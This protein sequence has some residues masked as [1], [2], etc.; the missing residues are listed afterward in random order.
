MELRPYQKQILHELEHLPAIGLFMGTGTGKTI[1]S[2]YRHI[3]NK[4][5]YLLILCPAKVVPQWKAVIPTVIKDIS[6]VNFKPS[7]TASKI[8]EE[9]SKINLA[10][11]SAIVLSLESISRI[12]ILEKIVDEQ[13]TLI[14]DES[15][16]IKEF[17]TK[18][19]PV[20]VTRSALAIG[21]KTPFKLILT[22]TP[23]QKEKGGYIDYYTQLSFLGYMD[24]SLKEFKDRY[25]I[26]T[27][28][29]PLGMP[30]PID[31]IKNYK[32]THEIDNL[33]MQCCRRYT[34]KFG[35]FEPQHTK[36]LLPLA[37]SYTKLSR[38]KAYKDLDLM[39]LSSRRIAKKTLTGGVVI[40]HDLYGEHLRYEDNT[41]K[42][43]WVSEFLSDTDERVVI[44]Y[45]YNV[46]L[47]TLKK[48]CETNNKRYIVINGDNKHKYQ[49]IMRD[50]YDVVLGQFAAAGESLDGLQYKAHI[51]VYYAMPESSLAHRQALGRIDRDGQTS[52]PMYYYLVMDKTIDDDIYKMTEKKIEFSEETLNKVALAEDE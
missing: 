20:K 24:M 28:F 17:G 1:T 46:E 8:N 41:I 49:D 7:Y 9:L 11:P 51:C 18:R 36:I 43:D 10:K 21:L 15:H 39:N 50:D 23:T 26:M 16:K 12:P 38:E 52:V 6:I 27:R 44:F 22:A 2:L 34:A 5:K 31:I 35:D 25:C 4:T 14:V 45:Q 29:Q 33:L 37:K 30:F 42:S 3:E 19:N 32:N 40:G 13:W 48:V 47:D